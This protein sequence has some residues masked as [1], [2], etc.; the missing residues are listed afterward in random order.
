[1]VGD[2]TGVLQN[3]FEIKPLIHV[4]IMIYYIYRPNRGL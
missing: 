2:Y 1:M 3:K 4:F